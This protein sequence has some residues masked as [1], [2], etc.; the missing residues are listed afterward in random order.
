MR[1]TSLGKLIGR[2]AKVESVVPTDEEKGS[3]EEHDDL[4]NFESSRSVGE[5][6][7]EQDLAAA[8]QEVAEIQVNEIALVQR[9]NKEWRYARLVKRSEDSMSFVVD[10][11][12][13]TKMYPRQRYSEVRRITKQIDGGPQQRSTD[14]SSDRHFTEFKEEEEGAVSLKIGAEGLGD[15]EGVDDFASASWINDFED[16]AEEE[17]E[18]EEFENLYLEDKD[19]LPTTTINESCLREEEKGEG[20]K[21]G[22]NCSSGSTGSGSIG[23]GAALIADARELL[24]EARKRKKKQH[25]KAKEEE[26]ERRRYYTFSQCLITAPPHCAIYTQCAPS[27]CSCTYSFIV[28]C[29]RSCETST[30]HSLPFLSTHSLFHPLTIH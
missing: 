11:A 6:A 15:Q 25:K 8:A 27:H 22:K 23:N 7:T 21:G 4:Y 28:L 20:G 5:L 13:Q 29:Q 16:Y 2:L 1:K 18:D 12:G 17:L 26:K 3:G 24:K 14:S 19:G 10:S 30:K 9:S